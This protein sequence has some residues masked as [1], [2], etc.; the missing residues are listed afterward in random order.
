MASLQ[1]GLARG[2]FP[3]GTPWA[4]SNL[5]FLRDTLIYPE[6]V[7]LAMEPSLDNIGW[8]GP[9]LNKVH[10][11]SWNILGIIYAFSTSRDSDTV[12]SG[13]NILLSSA[14]PVVKNPQYFY[15]SIL[16]PL[17]GNFTL[18]RVMFFLLDMA[19]SSNI[20][21]ERRRKINLCAA[22]CISCFS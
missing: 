17:W 22:T 4:P 9:M 5:E 20:T 18:F 14:S 8:M 12:F 10:F 7:L 6:S 3:A 13:W 2:H 1:L 19:V 21:S 11:L 15:S 16:N